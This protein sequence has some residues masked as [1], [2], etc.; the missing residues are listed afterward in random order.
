MMGLYTVSLNDRM[1]H[2]ETVTPRQAG[3]SMRRM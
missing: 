1:Y 3:G 2:A